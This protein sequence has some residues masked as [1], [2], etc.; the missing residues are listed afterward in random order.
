MKALLFTLTAVFVLLA[1]ALVQNAQSAIHEILGAIVLLSGMIC[2]SAGC[3]VAK[4]E[5]VNYNVR[6]GNR[7]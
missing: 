6:K 7:D 2:F 3:V 4:I 5:E 1:G